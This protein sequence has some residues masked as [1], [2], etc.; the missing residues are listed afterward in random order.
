[1]LRRLARR[2]ARMPS[3]ANISRERGS[4][5]F[6]LITTNVSPSLHTYREEWVGGWVG[7]EVGGWVGGLCTLRLKSMTCL[8]FSSVKRRSE[9]TSFSRSSA[10]E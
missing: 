8:T 10:L 1:M 4:M 3:L 7:E 9:E 5:P 2:R 6:W